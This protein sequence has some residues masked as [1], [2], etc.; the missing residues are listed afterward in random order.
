MFRKICTAFFFLSGISISIFSQS[1]RIQNLEESHTLTNI[2]YKIEN[3]APGR[4]PSSTAAGFNEYN[5]GRLD[6]IPEGT[7]MMYSFAVDFTLDNSLDSDD[8]S[9]YLGPADYPYNIYLNGISIMKHGSA[10]PDYITNS[11][12]SYNVY[13]PDELLKYGSQK[14]S[15]IVQA[16]PLF[17]TAPL[18]PLVLTLYKT[19]ARL[20]FYRNL[21]GVYLIRGASVLA[22]FLFIFFFFYA[23][24]GKMKNYNYIF[25]ALMCLSFVFSYF[26]IT[27]SYDSTN[28]ILIKVLAK[29]GFT[30]VA[31]ISI[32]FVTEY[33]GIFR[34]NPIRKILPGAL[35][36]LLTILFLTR[37]TKE[38][39]DAVYGPVTQF[40]FLPTILLNIT[41]LIISVFKQKNK[42]SI[43]LLISFVVIIGASGHDIAYIAQSKLPYA[44]LTAYG[45]LTLVVFIFF[46]LAINQ[47]SISQKAQKNAKILDEKNKQQQKMIEKIKKV[48]ET[49]ILSSRQ[50]EEKVSS[51]S[52]KIEESADE[53][54]TIS[55][56]VFSRVSELKQVIVEMEQ[57]M[58]V[59][60]EKMPLSI[61]NQSEAVREVS[62]TVHSLNE[63]LS[64]I[65]QF[66]DDTKNTAENLSEL[67]ENSTAVIKESNKSIIEVSEYSNF[68]G[69][70]LGSIE[71]ITEKTAL[72]SINAAI[73]AARAGA[74]G[75]GFSVVA[76][77]IRTLSSASKVQLDSSFQKI[78]DMKESI[79]NS[80]T[81]SDRVSG[82]LT[83]IIDN[84]KISTKKITSM[85]DRLNDQ[86]R[87]SAAIS[88]SI[89]GLL[90]DTRII[91]HLSEEGQ[92]ADIAVA[93]TMAEIRDLF[94]HITEILSKQKD[95][96]IELYN[97]MAHIQ[98]VV[99]ENLTNVDILN[100][101]INETL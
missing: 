92:T 42:K 24:L 80:R 44:Y 89:Q 68:I 57:R 59:S 10:S 70:V 69:E 25:F 8:L 17:E 58:K 9:I 21:A 78:E 76:G 99:E 23:V 40:I 14:N 16:Y 56:E 97:F 22:L 30:W 96:S 45:F 100:S 87:Q 84:T 12:E 49:L 41:L 91:R 61:K 38:A 73:E 60:A 52:E 6:N 64:E 48:S 55:G 95:E 94:L 51:T 4:L 77:E 71:D 88:Q 34:K 29:T 72:L 1:N 13:L 65:L 98:A 66:A 32:Y 86:K 35:G 20:T 2:R 39:L 93:Q 26:E 7:R 67:A 50:I 15:L 5:G 82:S 62:K 36:L 37:G 63:H 90:N 31:L 81:L 79:D 18:P 54:E 43:P 83:N 11:Y 33:T 53:N 75:A 3:F 46:T 47:A 74:S 27:F 85:T 28:E 19:G 101:C